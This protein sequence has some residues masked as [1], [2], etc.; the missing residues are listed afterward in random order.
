MPLTVNL[1]YPTVTEPHYC[2]LCMRTVW[3]FP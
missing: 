1:V 3:D 2:W